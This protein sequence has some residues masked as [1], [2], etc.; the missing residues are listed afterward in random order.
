[1]SKLNNNFQKE[2]FKPS[3]FG[4]F[5]HPFYFIRK[6]LYENILQLT[7]RLNGKLLDIGCGT[8]P[9]QDMCNVNEYIGLEIDDE[10]N[11][12]HSCA[13]V[14]YAGKAIP[15]DDNTFDSVL[16]SEVFEHVFNPDEFLQE[17]NRVT[18]MG[19]LFL[20]TV[21]FIWAE[22]EKPYDYAR[23]SSFGLKHILSKNGFE[24]IEHR[25]SGNG[26]E[27]I[28]QLINHYPYGIVF[29]D[30]KYVAKVLR[31]VSRLIRSIIRVPVNIIGLIL[32]K[33]LPRN[34]DLYLNNIVLAKKI[35]DME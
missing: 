5:R 33:V 21:P 31:S 2:N 29:P 35:R 27:L 20:I 30:N 1:M 13:D 19:G 11:R 12:N 14:F 6:G 16:S 26:A 24:V 15:F 25:K 7:P 4:L 17:V 32:S 22:H 8:K 3:L 23:Y 10:G 34:D 28:F 18:K 9:Y